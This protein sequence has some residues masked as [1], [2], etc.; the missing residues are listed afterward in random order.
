MPEL[1][2]LGL[3]SIKLV[4]LARFKRCNGTIPRNYNWTRE[5]FAVD[6]TE[7]VYTFPL[8]NIQRAS[9]CSMTPVVPG[10]CPYCLTQQSW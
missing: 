9:L 10:Y 5:W 8:F 6:S 4:D 1:F 3:D 2:T 7:T